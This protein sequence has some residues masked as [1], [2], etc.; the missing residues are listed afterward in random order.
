MSQKV[1]IAIPGKWVN[2]EELEDEILEVSNG[3]YFFKGKNLQTADGKAKCEIAFYEY[4]PSLFN[5]FEI[6]AR[7]QME[8]EILFDIV[9][10][11]SVVYL[12]FDSDSENLR[13]NI[14]GFST[15]LE[16][17]GGLAVKVETAGIAHSFETWKSLMGSNSSYDLYQAVTTVAMNEEVIYSCGMQQF[18]L[19]DACVPAETDQNYA[20]SLLAIFNH[21]QMT[22][23]TALKEGDSFQVAEDAPVHRLVMRDEF[24]YRDEPFFA[25][26]FGRWVLELAE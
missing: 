18:N 23:E 16:K 10:H 8:K 11:R 25:N 14:L 15:L 17:A 24:I 5:S 19:P 21:Y 12:Q 2:R 26:P 22:S 7:G 1:I 13:Y 3:E 4:N 6:A 20:L 9:N